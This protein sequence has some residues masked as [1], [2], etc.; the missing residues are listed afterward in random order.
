[1]DP[2]FD[3]SAHDE[4]VWQA[5]RQEEIASICWQKCE[6]CNGRGWNGQHEEGYGPNDAEYF[7][8][9]TC[10][11]CEGEGHVQLHDPDRVTAL[12]DAADDARERMGVW[13]YTRI[14]SA[15]SLAIN[16][17]VDIDES[18]LAT[19]LVASQSAEGKFYLISH[20]CGCNCYDAHYRAPRIDG[21]PH[22]KHQ[23]AVWLVKAA[24][25]KMS[26]G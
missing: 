23:I 19:I 5:E 16:G 1:M 9:I 7:L 13:C 8:R 3:L 25:K 26:N 22:C 24:E 15:L 17:A 10:H 20:D 12:Y 2:T 11:A 21:I 14:A 18:R 6:G 4:S